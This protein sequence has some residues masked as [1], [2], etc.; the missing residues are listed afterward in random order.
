MRTKK[1]I[2]VLLL[3][4]LLVSV[5]YAQAFVIS[6]M[7]VGIDVFQVSLSINGSGIA[8]CSAY[9]TT[10]ISSCTPTLAVTL[11]KSTNGQ[12][13]TS[14][15]SWS[16]TGTYLLGASAVETIA[17]ASGYQYKL[18]ATGRIINSEGVVIETAYKNSAAVAY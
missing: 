13:W 15:K 17:V 6:P 1:A 2:A 3:M 18:F 8:G 12:T 9:L 16:A 5:S 11:K 10:S 7:Y 14:V 4:C